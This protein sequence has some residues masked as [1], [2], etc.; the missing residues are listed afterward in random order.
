M[1]RHNEILEAEGVSSEPVAKKRAL[2]RNGNDHQSDFRHGLFDQDRLEQYASEYATSKPYKHGVIP[3]LLDPTL[4]RNVREEISNNLSFTPKETDIYKI[5]QSGDLANLDGLDDSA[6]KILPSLVVLRNALYSAP[7]REYLAKV[8]NSGPLSGGKTDMAVNVYTPTS[9][10]LCHDD[11]IGTRR[12]SYI[13]YLTDPDRP[14][15]PE[16]G[17]ALRLYPTRKTGSGSS[18][19]LTPWHEH[20]TSIP[21]SSNQL[22]FFAVQP[23]QS[24]HDVEEVYARKDDEPEEDDG[25]RVRMAISGW[26][27]IPQEGE[28]GYEEGVED[29]EAEKSSLAQLQ[30][31]DSASEIPALKWITH[32]DDDIPGEGFGEN[33][34]NSP[35]TELTEADLNFLLHFMNPRYLTP[36]T[37]L[38]L[39]EDFSENSSLRLAL[40]LSNNFAN[41]IRDRVESLEKGR[42]DQSLKSSWQVARPPHKHRYLFQS[43]STVEPVNE[44]NPTKVDPVEALNSYFLPSVP[45]KKWLSLVTGKLELGAVATLARRFRRG[46]DYT[47]ATSYNEPDPRVEVCV[48]ITPSTGWGGDDAEIDHDPQAP[49][50]ADET[51]NAPTDDYNDD[52]AKGLESTQEKPEELAVGG[53]E[54]YMAGDDDDDEEDGNEIEKGKEHIIAGSSHTGAGKRRITKADPAVYHQSNEGREDEDDGILFSQPASFNTLSI[55]LRDKGTLRFVKYVSATAKGDRWDVCGWWRVEGERSDESDEGDEE[56]AES[57]EE[58]EEEEPS[59]S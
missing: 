50:D 14:W 9:H 57:I 36:D 33:E 46:K 39:A 7:F 17:G 58:E 5:Y 35:D 11:V 25:G 27:H 20:T 30:A 28:E 2:Q 8:T 47:L 13:L 49:A 54:A 40:F 23:G 18:K 26:Y 12:V 16:W 48:G 45:F 53:Y 37:V 15:K 6:L 56:G 42:I 29:A 31:K 59:A 10:L 1:K 19:T 4:L 41:R 22:A 24:F 21:P 44:Q 38:E 32:A 43:P 51:Q 34:D 55:V 52:S 3:E